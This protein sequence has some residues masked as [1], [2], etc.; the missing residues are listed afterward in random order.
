[1]R[2]ATYIDILALISSNALMEGKF[3]TVLSYAVS[4]SL[5]TLCRGSLGVAFL[6]IQ[7]GPISFTYRIGSKPAPIKIVPASF[8]RR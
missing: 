2:Y 1:M 6:R 4:I 8:S 7:S 5:T 3:V